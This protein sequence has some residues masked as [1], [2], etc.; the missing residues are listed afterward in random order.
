MNWPFIIFIAVFGVPILMLFCIFV[1]LTLQLLLS[2]YDEVILG[3]PPT[4]ELK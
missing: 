4:E 2:F 1:M 3:N